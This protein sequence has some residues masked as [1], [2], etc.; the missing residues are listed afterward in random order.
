MTKKLTG[1]ACLANKAWWNAAGTR[2]LKTAA[3][4]GAASL[5]VTLI[6]DID[7]KVMIGTVLIAAIGSLLWSLA[8]IPEVTE[9]KE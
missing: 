6:W 1:L 9:E 8:G 4:A 7:W 2:A 3:Q 5:T